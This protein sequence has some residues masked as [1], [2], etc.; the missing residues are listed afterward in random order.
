MQTLFPFI[1]VM[2]W[3]GNMLVNRMAVGVI[4]PGDISFYRWLVAGLV[5]TPMC[6]PALRRNRQQIVAN[7]GKLFVLSLFGMVLYPSIA[8]VAALS[9]NAGQSGVI[10][11][12]FPVFT[13]V[14]GR[15][16]FKQN[17]SAIGTIGAVISLLGVSIFVSKGSPVNLFHE[18]I[19]VGEGWMIIAV[20]CYAFY[21]LLLKHWQSSIALPVWVSLN[22]QVLCTILL[23]SPIFWAFG[24]HSFNSHALGLVGYAGVIASLGAPYCWMR[25]VALLGAPRASIFMNFLPILS[26]IMAYMLLGETLSSIQLAAGAIIFLGV[27]LTQAPGEWL[28]KRLT[29]MRRRAA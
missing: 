12:L 9:I 14:L 22:V 11:G 5:L 28:F 2:I 27:S 17:I 6:W 23:L 24:E 3:S 20:L 10:L 7:L 4:V 8:Y 19:A 25:G 1:A 26:A 16:I 13:L 18:H 15:L 21:S 29:M